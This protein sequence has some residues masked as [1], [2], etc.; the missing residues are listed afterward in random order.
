MDWLYLKLIMMAE[1]AP[2]PVKLLEPLGGLKDGST[3]CIEQYIKSTF[4]LFLGLA[5]ILAILQFAYGGL[6][7][8]LSEAVTS[9]EDAK[10]RMTS[11]VW[12]VLLIL[13]SWIILYQINPDI[14]TTNLF[15]PCL[16]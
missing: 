1:A 2:Q 12:G 7:Y 13:A 15:E 4:N 10:H 14:L 5:S 6:L 3:T 9:K 11:S 8:M 16:K